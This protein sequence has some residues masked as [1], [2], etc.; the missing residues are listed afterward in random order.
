MGQSLL[1]QFG[2]AFEPAVEDEFKTARRLHAAIASVPAF[3]DSALYNWGNVLSAQAK[4]KQGAEADRLFAEAG[5]KYAHALEIKPDNHE[6]LNNWGNA[7]S[8]QAKTK[9]GAEADRLFAEAGARYAQ[10]LEIKPDKH[11]ALNNWGAALL[12]Q[13]KTK[14]G[15]EL[16]RYR[17]LA[18]GKLT[19]AQALRPSAAAFN[20][21][22]LESLSGNVEEAIRWLKEYNN[23]GARTIREEIA[24]DSD[25]D[26]IRDSPAFRDFLI[27]LQ[28]K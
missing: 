20:L 1:L 6:A 5:A 19:A 7:L 22:G 17:D 9:Q 14:Q 25:F 13:A 15:Q 26:L 3:R 21:A 16:K 8:D 10:A 28:E 18:R 12:E 2:N 24:K 4:T 23:S 27:T 11:D